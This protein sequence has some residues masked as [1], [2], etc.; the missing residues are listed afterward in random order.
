VIKETTFLG[1]QLECSGSLGDI[2]TVHSN[3]VDSTVAL[4][5]HEESIWNYDSSF[6]EDV[7]R[8]DL[9]AVGP[10]K[11]GSVEFDGLQLRNCV[12]FDCIGDFWYYIDFT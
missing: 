5:R 2:D 10:G 6:F 3:N 11:A 8:N 12:V 4:A 1:T 9:N 7:L